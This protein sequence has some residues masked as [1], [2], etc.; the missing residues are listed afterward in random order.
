MGKEVVQGI[1][2]E[3]RRWRGSRGNVVMEGVP[4]EKGIGASSRGKRGCW[5]G[6]GENRIWRGFQGGRR[7]RRGFQERITKGKRVQGE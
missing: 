1:P 3:R 7:M 2:G 5:G 6:P 4:R